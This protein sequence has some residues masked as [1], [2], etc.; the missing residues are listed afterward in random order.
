MQDAETHGFY[1]E[2]KFLFGYL[3]VLSNALA[4][5]EHTIAQRPQC[6]GCK[7]DI[8]KRATVEATGQCREECLSWRS[9]EHVMTD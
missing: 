5:F 1:N 6:I 8:E 7:E 3:L 2:G 4:W 9:I